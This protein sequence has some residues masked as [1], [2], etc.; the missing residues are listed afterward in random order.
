MID[1]KFDASRLK[2]GSTGLIKSIA[3]RRLKRFKEQQKPILKDL[4]KQRK[5]I[6]Q[7]PAK[8]AKKRSDAAKKGAATR[9]KNRQAA[10]DAANQPPKKTWNPIK[11]TTIPGQGGGAPGK[12]A[13]PGTKTPKA[14]KPAKAPKAPSSKRTPPAKTTKPVK[15]V[16]PVTKNPQRGRIR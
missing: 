5:E 2:G 12:P 14:S 3:E 8:A 1:P 10:Q 15:K 11:K 6:L 7:A 9:A 4:E 13:Q 16:G